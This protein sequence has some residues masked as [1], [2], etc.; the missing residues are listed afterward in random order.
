MAFK[1]RAPRQQPR[2]KAAT[3]KFPSTSMA[4][5]KSG[6]NELVPVADLQSTLN[7]GAMFIF[8]HL[9]PLETSHHAPR[10]TTGEEDAFSQSDDMTF[11]ELS[12]A[13][14]RVRHEDF[15]TDAAGK[16]QLS[17][18]CM[19]AMAILDSEDKRLTVGEIYEWIKKRFAYFSLE[20]VGVGWK[21]SVRHNLSLSKHFAKLTRDEVDSNG[22]GAYWQIVPES[23]EH[24]E[25]AISRQQKFS[26]RRSAHA[27]PDALLTSSRHFRGHVAERSTARSRTFKM[28]HSTGEDLAANPDAVHGAATVLLGFTAQSPSKSSTHATSL[29]AK[30]KTMQPP[31][32]SSTAPRARGVYTPSVALTGLTTAAGA[33]LGGGSHSPGQT[34][35][36]PLP[37]GASASSRSAAPSLRRGSESSSSFGFPAHPT[38]QV[39]APP[40]LFPT[41]SSASASIPISVQGRGLG[42]HASPA[43]LSSPQAADLLSMFA[44]RIEQDS[45]VAKSRSNPFVSRNPDATWQT[46][47][48]AVKEEEEATVMR[49]SPDPVRQQAERDGQ[50][51]A[52]A[53]PRP[54]YFK[55]SSQKSVDKS[56]TFTQETPKPA[57]TRSPILF[58]PR[59]LELSSAAGEEGM[60]TSTEEHEATHALLFLAA[61]CDSGM[62]PSFE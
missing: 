47:M 3:L 18:A 30:L 46:Q 25:L 1:M 39:Y 57:R 14:A 53:A 7:T 12:D 40:T 31:Q 13:V 26:P 8:Q 35:Q 42:P 59:R 20:G 5:A 54:N 45:A 49:T 32:L 37:F 62:A 10:A 17:F 44:T 9:K 55:F 51:D 2:D 4:A 43:P 19:I 27:I 22:K 33:I 50:L 58:P 34:S 21:N 24:L 56:N 15:A 41:S 60:D 6:D 28:P 29:S 16:P 61:A 52:M 48:I 36:S 11:D 38:P 23:L